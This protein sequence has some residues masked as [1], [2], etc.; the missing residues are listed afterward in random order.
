MRRRVRSTAG[1]AIGA[2]DSSACVYGWRALVNSS[3]VGATSTIWPRY[4]TATT[5]VAEWATALHRVRDEHPE[6]CVG[7]GTI[8]D[9]DMAWRAIDAGAQ[10][11]VTPRIDRAVRAVAHA[12]GIAVLEG[13]CTP[14]EV[15]G[16]VDA[17][18]IAK[19]FPAHVG[20]PQY[21]RSLLAVAPGAR[22][23]PTGG[24]RLRDA[25]EWLA[26]GAFAVGIGRDLIDAELSPAAWR[27]SSA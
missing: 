23:V 1:F 24:I 26:A 15:L 5:S 3:S 4:I 17:N 19:L 11:L 9:A 10:F 12:V 20:G 16:A 6:V 13:G 2:A 8:M 21:L 18:G 27:A 22:I 7:V 25:H 14:S